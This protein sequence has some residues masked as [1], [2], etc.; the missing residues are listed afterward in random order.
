M[1]EEMPDSE[2]V[3]QKERAKTRILWALIFL[4]ILLFGY[5]VYE[6]IVLIINLGK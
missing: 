1:I 6:I 2:K 3:A 5:A 4:D